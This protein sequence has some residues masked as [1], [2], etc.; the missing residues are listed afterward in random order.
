[1]IVRNKTCISKEEAITDLVAMARKDY[2]SRF[3]LSAVCFICGIA[4]IIIGLVNKDTSI[5]TFAYIFLA[6]GVAYSILTIYQYVNAP[7]KVRKVNEET[8][9]DGLN[10]EFVFKEQSLNVTIIQGEKKSKADYSYLDFKKIKETPE[11]YQFILSQSVIIAKKDGFEN[12]RM[13][14]FFINNIKKNKK[15]K[16]KL[17]KN[18]K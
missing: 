13:E 2:I 3:L 10:F 12:K 1:M 18:K 8:M 4:L 15:N 6:L 17:L 9:K 7:K 16:L 14:Q 11:S 5:N